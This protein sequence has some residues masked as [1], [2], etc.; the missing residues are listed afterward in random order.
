MSTAAHEQ[1]TTE[2]C[3]RIL[4]ARYDVS[5]PHGKC[6][7][8]GNTIDR[9]RRQNYGGASPKTLSGFDRALRFAR[10]L[11]DISIG[12]GLLAFWQT[13]MPRPEQTKKKLFVDD[14]VLCELF[15]R[16]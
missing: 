10:C 11:A 3:P 4:R 8:T 16:G 9:G 13:V 6:H 5:A 2:K 15:E 1:Q 7:V 12:T 14:Q